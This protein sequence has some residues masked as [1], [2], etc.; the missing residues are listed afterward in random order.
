MKIRIKLESLTLIGSR[1]NYLVSFHDGFNYISGHTSTGK[2]SVLEMINYAFGAKEHKSYI[3]IGNSCSSVELVV[4]FGSS[5]FKIKRKLFNFREAVIV[6]EWNDEKGTFLF[7]NRYEID[8]PKNPNS[9]SYF[10]IERLGLSNIN[11]S[12]QTFSFRDLYKY[13]YIKQTEIDNENILGEKNWEQNLKRRATFEIL[14]NIYDEALEEFKS[15]LEN[16]KNEVKE[17]E[18]QLA[19]IKKFLE[20]IEI[21]SILDCAKKANDIQQEINVLQMNLSNIKN[22]NGFEPGLS[23]RLREKVGNIK[24]KLKDIFEMRNDQKQYIDKLRLL[25]NQYISEIG[26]KELAIDGYIAFNKYEFVFCPNCLRPVSRMD[27]IEFCCLCGSEKNDDRIELVLIKKDVARIKRKANELLKFIEVEEAKYIKILH[28]ESK[29]KEIL[30][31]SELELQQLSKDYINPKIEQIEYL[32]YEIGRK[33]RLLFELKKNLTMFEELERYNK[34]ISDKNI[35]INILKNNIKILAANSTNKQFIIDS[36]SEKFKEI[37]KRFEYPMLSSAYINEKD[38][39]PYV[40]GHK[41]DDIGSLAGVTL[42]TMAYYLSV[43]IESSKD[44]FCHPN[45]LIIDS[46]RKNLGAQALNSEL[47]EFKDEKIFNATVRCLYEIAEE[48]KD[49]IQIII[50]NN[51]YPEFLPRKYI[52]AEFDSDGKSG[53]P[54]GLIDDALDE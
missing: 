43:M 2:T 18:I 13:C 49:R 36:I 11:I 21:D 9:L 4:L 32:N 31:E 16:K 10:L 35:S 7:Y 40:R 51:G 42:I 37:L 29:L 27:N 54:K 52:I 44:N 50:V 14:F 15:N 53:L 33:N 46:P 6:E 19:G 8:S 45:L 30:E 41:Y 25:Y 20:S 22:D 39:L 38:Y 1:K 48:M 28:N 47:E 12:R 24:F 17:L 23:M 3:E 5:K 26:K 34:I